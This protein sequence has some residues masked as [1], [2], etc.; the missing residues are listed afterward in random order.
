MK[1]GK[2]PNSGL[3]LISN[4][5]KKFTKEQMNQFTRDIHTWLQPSLYDL[6]RKEPIVLSR[7]H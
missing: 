6:G 2:H 3:R 1:D 5:N 4:G 7:R